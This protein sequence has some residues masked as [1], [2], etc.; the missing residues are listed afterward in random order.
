MIRRPQKST[1]FPY[2]ALFPSLDRRPDRRPRLGPGGGAGELAGGLAQL[3]HVL[4]RD[5]DRQVPLLA[6]LGRDDLH[7]PAAR[8]EE[9][10][11][12]LQ[13]RQY[14]VSRLLPEKQ[15]LTC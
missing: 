4:D 7:R 6:G 14:L 15:K 5:D 11:S 12:E 8:S 2:T 10:T 3:G 1:L 9:H 13:S